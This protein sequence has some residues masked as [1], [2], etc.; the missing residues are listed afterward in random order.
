M[1]NDYLQRNGKGVMKEVSVGDLNYRNKR[2][3]R[4]LKKYLPSLVDD[5]LGTLCTFYLASEAFN[6]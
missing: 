6:A 4:R 2:K 5:L 1:E 3:E